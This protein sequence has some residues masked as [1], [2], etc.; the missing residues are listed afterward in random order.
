MMSTSV[1]RRRVCTAGD[2]PH[3][4]ATRPNAGDRR[5]GPL[6]ARTAPASIPRGVCAAPG[7][8]QPGT[9]D[10][11]RAR[12]ARAA[13]LSARRGCAGRTQAAGERREVRTGKA[14]AGPG[15]DPAGPT[16]GGQRTVGGG[17]PGGGWEVRHRPAAARGSTPAGIPPPPGGQHGGAAGRAVILWQ[18]PQPV[19]T[20]ARADGPARRQRVSSMGD[21]PQCSR[22]PAVEAELLHFGV[23]SRPGINFFPRRRI[24]RGRLECAAGGRSGC[25]DVGFDGEAVPTAGRTRG[26]ARPRA[27]R[28]AAAGRAAWIGQ[29]PDCELPLSDSP[30]APGP[31]DGR[32]PR[33]PKCLRHASKRDSVNDR[34]RTSHGLLAGA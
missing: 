24:R 34:G 21:L 31:G 2:T 14:R 5:S 26:L 4:L 17:Q 19:C 9:D 22:M 23:R 33:S 8:S 3:I 28:V 12:G 1:P 10:F 16:L 32:G 30:F 11:S 27:G 20:K 25:V 13:S 7:G 15:I 29:S 6:R 18:Q